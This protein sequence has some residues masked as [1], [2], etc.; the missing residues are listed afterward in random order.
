MAQWI[1]YLFPKQVVGGSS[2]PGRTIGFVG[3]QCFSANLASSHAKARSDLRR[4]SAP[5]GHFQKLFYIMEGRQGSSIDMKDIY[6]FS[7]AENAIRESARAHQAVM[8]K[9]LK[10]TEFSNLNNIFLMINYK[11]TK[12]FIFLSKG[13]KNVEVGVFLS[14]SGFG[15]GSSRIYKYCRSGYLDSESVVLYLSGNILNSFVL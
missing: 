10:K 4:H 9:C 8:E 3:V 11:R 12:V 14:G 15:C 5:D 6:M 13:V 1:G 2:P 7:S